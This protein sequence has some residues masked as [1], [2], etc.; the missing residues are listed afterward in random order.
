M[1]KSSKNATGAEGQTNLLLFDPDKLTVVTDRS[2]PLYDRRA[3]E[4]PDEALVLSIMAHG[5]KQPVAVRH[6]GYEDDAKE[7]PIVEVVAGRRRVIAARDANKRLR[8]QGSEPVRVPAVL[9]RGD[10]SSLIGT[11]IIE[12][13]IRKSD[14]TLERARKLQRYLDTGK[15]L[16]EAAIVFGVTK[17]TVN[18][19][20]KVL[21]LHP[22][23][24]RAIEREGVPVNVVKEL[25]SMP[26]EDQPTALAKLINA[27]ATKGAKGIEA[28]RN[29][30]N[31]DE[32]KPSKTL[33]MMAKPSIQQWCN[34]LKKSDG[35]DAELAAAVLSR[36]LG[37]ERALANYPRLR[38][39]L[40]DVL[41]E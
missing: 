32:A 26:Q 21:E 20:L 22:N 41:G 18:N 28:A 34:K 19:Y 38:E 7:Q 29:V 30:R 24:Q 15:T 3:E 4:P 8:A 10:Q 39:S 12:N 1:G 25:S 9:V 37:H 13:E 23:V 33:R 17:A 6:N 16:D 11:M 5:I 31:G 36:L 35:K 2:H 14:S 27:G 40:A